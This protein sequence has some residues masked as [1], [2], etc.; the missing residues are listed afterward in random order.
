MTVRKPPL[1]D[2]STD[3]RCTL[4]YYTYISYTYYIIYTASFYNIMYSGRDW[5]LYLSRSFAAYTAAAAYNDVGTMWLTITI[6][7]MRWTHNI[8]IYII[9]KSPDCRRLKT[10][11]RDTYLPIYLPTYLLT[12]L[13]IYRELCKSEATSSKRHFKRVLTGIIDNNI[14]Y[15]GH[16]CVRLLDHTLYSK[17]V[18]AF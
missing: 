10:I 12:Y 16:L 18:M 11:H 5:N 4:I 7:S 13:P 6:M 15:I 3:S 14:R 8:I 17:N 9:L 2:S 1:G